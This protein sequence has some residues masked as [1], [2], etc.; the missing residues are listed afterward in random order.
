MSYTLNLE[1]GVDGAILTEMASNQCN[2]F[3][4]RA[5]F[6]MKMV[7]PHN[8]YV[9][10]VQKVKNGLNYCKHPCL[11]KNGLRELNIERNSKQCLQKI[12]VIKG[13]PVP[14][15]CLCYHRLW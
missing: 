13:H 2:G 6:V 3:E 10:A 1:Y 14:F 11:T 8:L 4:E 15:L 12:T 5:H 7:N 9:S